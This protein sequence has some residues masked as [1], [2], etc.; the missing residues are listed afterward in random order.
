MICLSTKAYLRKVFVSIL[1][2][3]K[4][5]PEVVYTTRIQNAGE[6]C[7]QRSPK[8]HLLYPHPIQLELPLFNGDPNCTGFSKIFSLGDGDI[9]L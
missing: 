6:G 3:F 4:E 5:S 9:N 7:H 1:R 2:Y 8:N